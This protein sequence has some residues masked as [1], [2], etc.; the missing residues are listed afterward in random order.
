M[1]QQSD[2]EHVAL[3][4]KA[5]MEQFD[6]DMEKVAEAMSNPAFKLIPRDIE[7]MLMDVPEADGDG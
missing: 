1:M 5:L 3:N 6:G 2:R 7:R 4:A